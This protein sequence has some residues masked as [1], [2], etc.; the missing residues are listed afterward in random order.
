MTGH[1]KAFRKA[2]S[3]TFWDSCVTKAHDLFNRSQNVLS[4]TA[5]LIPDFLIRMDTASP[6]AD[7]DHIGDASPYSDTY[8]W[9]SCRLPWRLGCDYLTTGDVRARD[10]GGKL[11]SFLSNKHAGIPGNITSGYFMDGNEINPGSGYHPGVFID[12]LAPAAMGIPAQQVYLN[13]IWNDS[14]TRRPTGYY[15]TEL[16]LLSMVV[17]A[18]NW[19]AY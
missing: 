17:A 8:F 5:K 16:H 19:W 12:T 13:A 4:P 9:N 6:I 11:V 1:Y 15:G 7:I 2:T 14:N 10:V 18:G 3:D